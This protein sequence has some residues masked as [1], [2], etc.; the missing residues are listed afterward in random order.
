MTSPVEQIL[1]GKRRA[2][3]R[4][5]SQIE[6]NPPAA[7]AALAALYP[8]T[9]QAYLVG[10]TGPPGAG[11]ST[12]VN[13]LAKLYRR[14]NQTVAILSVDP[15]SPFSGGAILGDRVRL[16]D[17]SG[18]RGVFM[19]SMATRGNLGG[20][21]RAA[22]DAVKVFD[23][24]GFQIII[25]ETVGVGQAEVEIARLAHSVIVVDVPGLGDD[26]QAI[27]AGLLEIADIFVVNKADRD[28]ADR[29]AATLSMMLDLGSHNMPHTILHH[30]RLMEIKPPAQSPPPASKWRPPVCKTVATTGQ[31]VAEVIEA[32]A[33]HHTYQTANGG[34]A[35]RE[36]SRLLFE[37]EQILKERLLTHFME[38]VSTDRLT[39]TIQKISVRQLDP[40]TAV[41]NLLKTAAEQSD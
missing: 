36:Y 8:H 39:Q 13:E 7:R 18:D 5:I 40:Y 9:G 35:Q 1:Q 29:T 28:G 11:K 26:I 16:K 27:K 37:I 4:Q 20:L 22:A 3:A 6:N 14:Q 32:L 10:I 31:G 21:A 25:I 41:D 30:G 17:L 24:A 33:Q 23:A 12:L 19:R 2:I 15:T 38:N 34:L